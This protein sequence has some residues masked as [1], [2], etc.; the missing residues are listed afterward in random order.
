MKQD[1]KIELLKIERDFFFFFTEAKLSI[2]LKCTDFVIDTVYGPLL[3]L[4][5]S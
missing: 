4:G 3:V 5:Y 2:L 1:D